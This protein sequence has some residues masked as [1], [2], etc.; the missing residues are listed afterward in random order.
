MMFKVRW[1]RVGPSDDTL[2]RVLPLVLDRVGPEGGAKCLLVCKSWRREMEARGVC[3]KT[4]Q[5][6]SALAEGGDVRSGIT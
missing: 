4:L 1:T 3:T 6:C 5:L 2:Q